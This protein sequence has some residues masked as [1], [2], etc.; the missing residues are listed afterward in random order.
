MIYLYAAKVNNLFDL[1]ESNKDIFQE[2]MSLLCPERR[3][4]VEAGKQPKDKARALGAG[5]LLQSA[6]QDYL[7]L[8]VCKKDCGHRKE[9]ALEK[10]RLAAK[11]AEEAILAAR[12]A[13]E[14]ARIAAQQA[15][16]GARLAAQKAEEKAR[17]E[18]EKEEERRIREEEQRLEEER[19]AAEAEAALE[20]QNEVVVE[21]EPDDEDNEE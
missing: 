1:Y 10:A 21:A 19:K 13:E 12:Q 14:E 7:S 5:I 17:R 11:R 20:E 4:K 8:S 6:L 9:E 2:K 15:E 18:A 3:K 16:E